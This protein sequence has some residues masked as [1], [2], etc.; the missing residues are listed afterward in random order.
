MADVDPK[1]IGMMNPASRFYNDNIPAKSPLKKVAEEKMQKRFAGRPLLSEYTP[2]PGEME[3][4]NAAK[5]QK[6]LEQQML[7]NKLASN[8][9]VAN[10][11]NNIVEPMMALESLG[12]LGGLVKGGLKG[13]LKGKMKGNLLSDP[14]IIRGPIPNPYKGTQLPWENIGYRE[15]ATGDLAPYLTEY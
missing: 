2:I 14:V 13:G 11:M 7:L 5:D 9:Q 1:P 3:R 4:M 15:P 10:A 12:L 8:P 6:M